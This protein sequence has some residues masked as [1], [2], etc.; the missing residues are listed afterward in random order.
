ML[1]RAM[2]GGV[3]WCLS[4]GG[5]CAAFCLGCGE[6]PPVYE[7][8]DERV[9]LEGGV[10]SV[11]AS[12]GGAVAFSLALDGDFLRAARVLP[13]VEE[14][15]ASYAFDEVVEVACER[16]EVRRAVVVG[17][18]L[19]LAGRLL[20]EG[21]RAAFELRVMLAP[22][23]HFTA[24][25]EGLPGANRITL[26]MR[27]PPDEAI[28]GLGAQYAHV[29]LNGLALPVWSE[30]QGIGRGLEPLSSLAELVSPGSSGDAFSTYAPSASFVTTGGRAFSL[31]TTEY[32]TFD[33]SAPG[34]VV[35]SLWAAEMRGHFGAGAALPG[36]LEAQSEVVG[37][38]QPLPSWV[39]EGA[40]VR[41]HGGSSAVRARVAA[42]K[43]AGVPLSAVW[44]EDW[45]GE[46]VSQ[47]ANRL[48]W[49]WEP[50]ADLYPD[51]PALVAELRREGIRV[52]SYFNPYLVDP[53]AKPNVKRNLY[54]EAV[55][56]G[57]LVVDTKGEPLTIDQGDFVANI[58]DLSRAPA[59]AW[60]ADLMVEQLERG[61]SG[62]MAD[63]GEGFPLGG[64][65][66]SGE[67]AFS[68]HNRYPLAWA[69]LNRDVLTRA[70]KQ[71]DALFFSRSGYTTSPGV[72][73]LFW[74]GDQTVTWDAFDGMKTVVR[75][76]LSSGLSGFA[77]NHSDLGGYTSF[78]LEG[79]ID[80]VRSRELLLRWME[81]AAF[82][83]VYRTHE[84]NNRARNL[85]VDSDP[86]LLAAFARF[87]NV[88]AALADYRRSL[89]RDAAERGLP[90]VR[91]MALVFPGDPE[92]R[93]LDQQYMLGDALLVAPV[94]DPADPAAGPSAVRAYLPAGRWVHLF[95]GQ[96]YG[97][98]GRAGYATIPAPLGQ[99]PV[100]YRAGSELGAALAERL[101][102]AGI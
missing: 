56:A 2:R 15:A 96:V 41:M 24:R 11:R 10:L 12:R 58:V 48:W 68:Y 19:S 84:T 52:L 34:E 44:L 79:V 55:A 85:Q 66:A 100:L 22:T 17:D 90:L 69:E 50:D 40:I 8:D 81:L 80:L 21:C 92:V 46:R 1:E 67:D 3:G 91:H 73:T 60:L 37:R 93:G 9:M 5:L 20:G 78:T 23:P 64:V 57:Y 62:W 97:E 30:E 63:F 77:L 59:R 51:W 28:Y 25:V 35:V 47:V 6:V 61:V 87:A 32:V 43:A 94:L 76:L 36:A 82:T 83:P 71:G 27:V 4:L 88:Y 16:T 26:R 13:E 75:G 70:G 89:E 72:S 38:M 101:S 29:R 95:T 7:L 45:V 42:M 33:F 99:P 65:P 54:A 74:L 31:S 18:T 53:S 98:A 102:A 14:R 86:E 49:N 39:H